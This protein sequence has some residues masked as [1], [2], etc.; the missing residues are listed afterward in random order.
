MKM[1]NAGRCFCL[2]TIEKM[3]TPCCGFQLTNDPTGLCAHCRTPFPNDV[4]FMCVK[5]IIDSEDIL[6]TVCC[7]WSLHR[8]CTELEVRHNLC[9]QG[10]H[11][12]SGWKMDILCV[13]ACGRPSS[14]EHQLFCY[15]SSS[16]KLF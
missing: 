12:I 5:P 9:L 4:C 14:T 1:K 16:R 6:K 3:E 13:D 15:I 8:E 2:E 7:Q 11:L 10:S